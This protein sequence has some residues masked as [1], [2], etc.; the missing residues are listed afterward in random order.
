[1][2]QQR[3][4]RAP[5]L[6]EKEREKGRR[7]EGEKGRKALLGEERCVPLFALLEKV[8]RATFTLRPINAKAGSR[9][10]VA[11]PTTPDPC[12][13][14]RGR[15]TVESKNPLKRESDGC[16]CALSGEVRGSFDS[17]TIELHLRSG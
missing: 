12:H 7:G 1:M 16:S 13:S 8:A 10:S 2:D 4:L 14:E 17:A 5:F 6:F 3:G 15:P 11:L 9:C